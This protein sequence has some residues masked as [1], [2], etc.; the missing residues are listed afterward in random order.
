MCAFQKLGCVGER[1]R[2]LDWVIQGRESKL[3]E[4]TVD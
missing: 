3:G 2:K 4:K 1:E